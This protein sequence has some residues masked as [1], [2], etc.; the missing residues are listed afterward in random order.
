MHSA[1][2]AWATPF[3]WPSPRTI[4]S[5]V[6][7]IAQSTNSNPDSETNLRLENDLHDLTKTSGIG[8]VR[9]SSGHH[10]ATQKSPQRSSR[11]PARATRPH[12]FLA[13]GVHLDRVLMIAGDGVTLGSP[14]IEGAS[15][16]PGPPSR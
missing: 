1:I 7:T 2:L 10:P 6:S 16:V 9:G 5:G 11:T 4:M 15:V 3:G 14:T 8:N 13:I 12:H